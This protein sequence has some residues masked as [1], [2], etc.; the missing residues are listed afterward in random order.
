MIVENKANVI[1]GTVSKS[2]RSEIR[3][4]RSLYKNRLVVD[5]RL[6]F[7]PKGGGKF[8]PSRKGLT[9]DVA[10]AEDLIDVLNRL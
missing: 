1:V 3:V 4:S 2:N 6:W 8:I 5:I 10:K 7:L 9:I